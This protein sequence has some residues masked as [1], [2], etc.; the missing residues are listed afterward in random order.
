MRDFAAWR[1][2]TSVEDIGVSRTVARNLIAEA[3]Q[4]ETVTVAEISASAFRV[5]RVAAA[6]R[7]LPAS[8]RRAPG[9]P[10]AIVIGYDEWVRRFDADPDII[11]RS[12]QLGSDDLRD[13]RR[14]AGGL[15]LPG[16]SQLLD[17]VAA[18]SV[19]VRAAHRSVGQ[20]LRPSRAG[21]DA[22]E[23]AGRAD[24]DRTA[25]GRRRHR[26]RTSTCGR[27]SCPT[28]TRTTTWAIPTTPWRC[29]RSSSRSC[30]CS[31]S[32]A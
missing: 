15:R 7:P 6:A 26:R 13:R 22:R 23:R 21:R 20:R 29:A 27:G 16:Q 8:R 9:A 14:D 32:C 17:S 2:L 25:R 12:L 19:R 1:E 18:R 30:C 31:S 3:D 10:D 4:P 28:P 11:G 5:A 24:G